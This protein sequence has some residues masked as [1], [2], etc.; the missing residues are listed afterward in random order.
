[1]DNINTTADKKQYDTSQDNHN[2][3]HNDNHNDNDN[4]T[5]EYEYQEQNSNQFINKIRNNSND[6][7]DEYINNRQSNNE[8]RELI[9]PKLRE[10]FLKFY[11]VLN[12]KFSN[13]L[14]NADEEHAD[15]FI[16]LIK[17]HV[18]KNKG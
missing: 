9:E 10:H 3:I 4:I 14:Y 11:F 7:T 13:V 18:V 2:D 12:S 5:I 6:D 15:D 1:M 8:F 17:Y 16:N